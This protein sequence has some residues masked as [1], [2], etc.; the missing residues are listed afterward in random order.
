MMPPLPQRH[1]GAE[2]ACGVGLFPS[3]LDDSNLGNEEISG[4]GLSKSSIMFSLYRSRLGVL[5]VKE[6]RGF[7]GKKEKK[8]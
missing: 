3:F 7:S 4:G 5:A 6:K 2:D 1:E 8:P